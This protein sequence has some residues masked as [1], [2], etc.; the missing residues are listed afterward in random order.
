MPSAVAASVSCKH[1]SQVGFFG[2]SDYTNMTI[3]NFSDV[4]LGT[5]RP[6]ILTPQS[7]CFRFGLYPESHPEL[8]VANQRRT[9]S[10]PPSSTLSVSTQ[11]DGNISSRTAAGSASRSSLSTSSS[12][13]LPTRLSRSLRSVSPSPRSNRSKRLVFVRM[14]TSLNSLRAQGDGRQG[15]RGR[16][17]GHPPRGYAGGQERRS[18]QRHRDRQQGLRV[19]HLV[20]EFPVLYRRSLCILLPLVTLSFREI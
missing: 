9:V 19:K 17:E 15:H 5:L 20:K 13:R 14:L 1:T 10:S 12:P 6:Y 11:S 2:L 7:R 8:H 18:R 4:S 16:R 3:A